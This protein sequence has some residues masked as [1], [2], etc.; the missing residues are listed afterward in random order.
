M[1]WRLQYYPQRWAEIRRSK[2]LPSCC[3]SNWTKNPPGP[4]PWAQVV[5]SLGEAK[6]TVNQQVAVRREQDKLPAWMRAEIRI[7][8]ADGVPKGYEEMAGSIFAR[9]RKQAQSELMLGNFGGD[10]NFF[11]LRFPPRLKTSRSMKMTK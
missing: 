10:L 5:V 4:Q 6:K 1:F 11:K 9:W 7:G 8:V 2:R 3:K